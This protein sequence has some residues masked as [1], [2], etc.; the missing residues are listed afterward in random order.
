LDPAHKQDWYYDEQTGEIRDSKTEM[1]IDFFDD[2]GAGRLAAAAPKMARAL[3]RLYRELEEGCSLGVA[4]STLRE[5][6]REAGV[7]LDFDPE[8]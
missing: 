4:R 1:P 5:S 6:L 3:A 7:P 2:A 8:E